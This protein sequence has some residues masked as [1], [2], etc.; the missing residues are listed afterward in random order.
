MFIVQA[1][2]LSIEQRVKVTS[3]TT[4]TKKHNQ[5]GDGGMKGSKPWPVL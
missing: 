1:T 5:K 3:T 4:S 2:G